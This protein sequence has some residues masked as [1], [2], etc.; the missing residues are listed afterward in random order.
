MQIDQVA[1]CYC[2]K[3]EF[4]V[5]GA[6]IMS[7]LCHCKACTRFCSVSPVHIIGVAPAAG[8]VV[9]KGEEFVK[10]VSDTPSGKTMEH[11]FC[12]ECGCGLWQYPKEING[13]PLP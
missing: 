3:I 2:E 13:Q 4:T 5:K 8:V 11:A 10:T 6:V 7:A 9:T 12:S 1:K